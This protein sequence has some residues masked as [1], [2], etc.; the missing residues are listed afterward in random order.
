MQP[1]RTHILPGASLLIVILVAGFGLFLANTAAAQQS[2]IPEVAGVPS[3][4]KAFGRFV[5][6]SV[7]RTGGV[8]WSSKHPTAQSDLSGSLVD[9]RRS[10]YSDAINLRVLNAVLL[11]LA[12]FGWAAICNRWRAQNRMGSS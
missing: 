5:E 8:L 4:P 6:S 10:L 11:S 12:L 7:Y 3:I 2:A 1:G 9:L